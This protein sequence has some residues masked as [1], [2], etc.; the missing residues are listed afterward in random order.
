[1]MLILVSCC[2]SNDL[3][4]L[5]SGRCISVIKK[6]DICYLVPYEYHE[7]EVPK[8]NYIKCSCHHSFTFY[9]DKSK[10]N[11]VILRD[12]GSIYDKVPYE[13]STS[14]NQILKYDE[15]I[16]NRI[17]PKKTVRFKDVNSNIEFISIDLHERYA[18]S[19][20]KNRIAPR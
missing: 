12:E 3:Y 20:Y 10:E 19:L 18:S 4:F 2:S 6:N 11:E 7:K 9:F 16:R 8:L 14:N 17:Y 1:M 5:E 15:S 13:I